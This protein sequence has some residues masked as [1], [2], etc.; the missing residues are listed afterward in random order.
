M[1]HALRFCLKCGDEDKKRREAGCED[2]GAPSQ[3]CKKCEL[4][5]RQDEARWEVAG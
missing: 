1:E 5:G 3:G 2:C 4:C